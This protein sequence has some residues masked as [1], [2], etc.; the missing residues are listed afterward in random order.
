MQFVQLALRPE[1]ICWIRNIS[2]LLHVYSG[3]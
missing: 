3:Y 1:A 2:H